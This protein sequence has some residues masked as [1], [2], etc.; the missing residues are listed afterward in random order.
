MVRFAGAGP[1]VLAVVTSS[2]DSFLALSHLVLCAR[3][4]LRREA[5]DITRV[6]GFAFRDAPD[7]FNDSITEIA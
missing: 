1:V 3:A 7:P 2:C 5:A 4:I 6:G